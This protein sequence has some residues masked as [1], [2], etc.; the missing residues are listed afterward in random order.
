MGEGFGG[1]WLHVCVR[2]SPSAAHLKPSQHCLLAI[3]QYK[4]KSSRYEEKKESESNKGD[5]KWFIMVLSILVKN[6]KHKH[7]EITNDEIYY[8]SATRCH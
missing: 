1:E 4:I 6:C 2:L 5:L 3:L 8:G 7:L